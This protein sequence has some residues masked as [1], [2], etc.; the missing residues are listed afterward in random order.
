MRDSLIANFK[1]T[2][3]LRIALVHVGHIDLE[4]ALVKGSRP[5]CEIVYVAVSLKPF[6]KGLRCEI[7]RGGLEGLEEVDETERTRGVVIKASQAIERI[8]V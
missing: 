6:A 4:S 3:H 8:R 1:E 5:Q 7:P 2:L